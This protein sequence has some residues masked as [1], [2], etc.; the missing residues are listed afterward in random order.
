LTTL[1]DKCQSFGAIR[2]PSLKGIMALLGQYGSI[3]GPKKAKEYAQ[4]MYKSA[5]VRIQTEEKGEPNIEHIPTSTAIPKVDH[6]NLKKV[7]S[8]VADFNK[9][10]VE[11]V[12]NRKSRVPNFIALNAQV[13]QI[14][15]AK[16]L[17]SIKV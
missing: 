5:T 15:Q 12:Q 13:H 14:N 3:L 10:F 1:G 16:E 6:R 11:Y 2:F 4:P 9:D 7:N 17:L 8:R